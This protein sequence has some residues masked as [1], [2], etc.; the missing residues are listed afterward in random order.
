MERKIIQNLLEWK[1]KAERL[2]LIIHGARQIGKTYIIKEVFAKHFDD[3]FYI[4]LERDDAI[5]SLF[6]ETIEPVSVIERLESFF[7]REINPDKTLIVFDEIQAS[8][9]A[10][11]SL[12]YFCE[13]VPQYHIIA[14][15]SLLGVALNRDR[16]SFPVGKVDILMMY[17]MDFEEF[18]TAIDKLVLVRK[19]R[20]C[21]VANKKMDEYTH[22][23]LIDLYKKYLVIGGMPAAVKHYRDTNKIISITEIHNRIIMEYVKDMSKYCTKAEAV[24]IQAAYNSIPAQLAKDNRKFQYKVVKKGGTAEM[25]ELP[26]AWLK[27][28]G[29]ILQC[30]K[31][32][33]AMHPLNAYTDST[34]FKVYMSDTG[35]LTCKA[36]LNISVI[37]ENEHN[38][39][40]GALTENYV[41]CALSC[42]GHELKYWSS[43]GSADVDFLIE[44]GSEVI[45]VEVKSKDSTTSKS[46]SEF[47]KRH[48]P[49]YAVRLSAKNFGCTNSI[50]A[51]P[52]YA[53]F[54]LT[55]EYM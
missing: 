23:I 43:G 35:L 6:N 41:A 53:A 47:C 18:L 30:N 42:N 36:G 17:P 26:L 22:N 20:E 49:K 1:S 46:L 48:K 51:V 27:T 31:V 39:F 9:R 29:V 45:P 50:K 52:L 38:I 24:K 15:G 33:T 12:K 28:A 2:P 11:T 54:C 21:F 14:A 10:L 16:Y 55:K 8:E 13:D 5:A 3:C 7:G 32:E 44:S 40:K 19:I 34:Y 25:Y 4:D 37:F